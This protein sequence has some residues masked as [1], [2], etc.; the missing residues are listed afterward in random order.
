MPEN[1]LRYDSIP[2]PATKLPE[3]LG[4]GK[5]TFPSQCHLLIHPLKGGGV[6]SNDN[7]LLFLLVFLR[8]NDT[9]KIFVGQRMKII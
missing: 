8:D 2:G 1:G 6:F 3:R 7:T 5:L 4:S 9:L